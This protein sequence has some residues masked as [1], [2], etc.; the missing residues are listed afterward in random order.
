MGST[1]QTQRDGLS[2]QQARE[3]LARDGP[4]ELPR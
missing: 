2:S 3:R 4:N 1:S